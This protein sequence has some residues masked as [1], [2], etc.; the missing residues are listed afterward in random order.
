GAALAEPTPDAASEAEP[1]T[2]VAG[3]VPGDAAADA[4]AADAA[5]NA[6]ASLRTEQ[7]AAE[8]TAAEGT[9]P[10]EEVATADVEE[11]APVRVV[12]TTTIGTATATE[13]AT[14][15]AG[16]ADATNAGNTTPIPVTRPVDQPVDVVGTVTDR[17]NVRETAAA[18]G[19]QQD[20]AVQATAA[21]ADA[22]E[23]TQQQAAVAN[24]GGYVIQ[25]ASL[26]SEAEAKRSYDN[27]SSRFA[28]V[29]G[30]RGV[31]IRRAEIPNKG[32][33]FRVRIPAGSREEANALCARYKGAGGSCLVTR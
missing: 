26:P 8:G 31:D 7:A 28:S 15:E 4:V 16:D 14:A 10:L 33:Y 5:D 30:G 3:A 2:A 18:T 17:G 11:T 13:T 12:K 23:T 1:A 32:T 25:I 29:I 22:A 20:D 27:L 24:P 6:D 19:V 9:S 21:Q